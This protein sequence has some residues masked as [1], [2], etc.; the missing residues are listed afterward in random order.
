[1]IKVIKQTKTIWRIS[2]IKNLFIEKKMSKLDIPLDKLNKRQ[3]EKIQIN[4]IRDEQSGI[5]TDTKEIQSIIK[6]HFKMYIP[7]Y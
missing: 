5:T 3:K 4:K 7:S 6:T 1:M 2:E